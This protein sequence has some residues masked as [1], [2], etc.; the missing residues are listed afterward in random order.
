MNAL[1]AS[2][3]TMGEGGGGGGVGG[4]STVVMVTELKPSVL[5]NC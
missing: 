5:E 2:P 3:Y 4:G 1:A